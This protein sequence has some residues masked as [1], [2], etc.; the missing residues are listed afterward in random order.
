MVFTPPRLPRRAWSRRCWQRWPRATGSGQAGRQR[1]RD[2]CSTCEC[3]PAG[4]EVMGSSLRVGHVMD[5]EITLSQNHTFTL[6]RTGTGCAQGGRRDSNPVPV[7]DPSS[8]TPQFT[9]GHRAPCCCC[10]SCGYP[11][12]TRDASVLLGLA[13]PASSAGPSH[14]QQQ[15]QQHPLPQGELHSCFNLLRG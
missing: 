15:Q 11:A 6:T 12:L 8:H 3:P 2:D 13:P 10:R 4:H 9:L 14:A 1:L 5:G 7:L